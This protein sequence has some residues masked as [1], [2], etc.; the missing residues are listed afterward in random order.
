MLHKQGSVV[1]SALGFVLKFQVLA[2]N[3]GIGCTGH[4]AI[5]GFVEGLLFVYEPNPRVSTRY[6]E[7][8][9]V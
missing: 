4:S 1:L 2:G 6:D 5:L 8:N 9:V 3:R 7:Q